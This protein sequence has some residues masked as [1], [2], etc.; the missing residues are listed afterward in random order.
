MKNILSAQNI[1]AGYNGRQVLHQV[2]LYA[3]TGEKILLIG[4]NGSGKTTLL[5]VFS[6]VLLP[7]TGRVI[8][9]EKDISRIPVHRRISKGLG[10]LMQTRN[11]FPSLT[12]EE[13]LHLCFWRQTGNYAERREWILE[14]FPMLKDKLQRRAGLLSGGERQALAI[15][16]VLMRPVDLLLLD[17]PTAG[18]S[19]KAADTIL[20]AV[21]KAQ[22][23][24]GF[25]SIM[26]EHNLRLV[27]QWISRVLV[28]NQGR[29]IA[30]EKD[31]SVLMNQEVL[32]RYYFG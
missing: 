31:S 30:E 2:S 13:N 25:T 9:R 5:K 18:L 17:E 29:I 3:V 4:P 24:I 21:H 16:M 12:V 22:K 26:V 6:G 28:M 15:S 11:I 20:Q 19:P 14:V 23:T 10:Y 1:S 27:H 7:R 32:Q 8:F